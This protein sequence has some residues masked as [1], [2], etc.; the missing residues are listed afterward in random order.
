MMTEQRLAEL[1][2]LAAPVTEPQDMA[3]QDRLSRARGRAALLAVPE[4]LA[5]VERLR[6]ENADLQ[7]RLKDL[8]DWARE[9]RE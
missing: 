4:L 6:K 9:R 2:A 5:E 3:E 8:R 7:E 1:R